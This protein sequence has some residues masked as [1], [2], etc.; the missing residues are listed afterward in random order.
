[1]AGLILQNRLSLN[2]VRPDIFFG[3][4]RDLIKLL[5]EGIIEPEELIM[6][7]GLPTYN[8][9]IDAVK[10]VNGAGDFNWVQILEETASK[11]EAGIKLEKYGRKLQHGEDIDWSSLVSISG[12]VQQNVSGNF[13]PLSEV[14]GG[15]V[16]LIPIGWPPFDEHVGGLPEVGLIIVAGEAGVGKTTLMV[17]MA[18]SSAGFHKDKTVLIFSLEMILKEIAG[19]IRET[20]KLN[21]DI[22]SRIL[23]N[24]FPVTPE[25][26]INKASTV[27]NPGLICVDFADYMINGEVTESSMAHIYKTLAL[28]AKSLH[29]PILLLS[30]LSYKYAGGIPRPHHI[31]YT[32]L[33][34]ALGWMILMP[35]NPSEDYYADQ[36]KDLLPAIDGYSYLIVWKVRG[37]FR[38]H[39]NE[40]PG[41]IQ[42]QFNGSHGWSPVKGRWFNLRKGL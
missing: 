27:E 34:K 35:Y 15:E 2:Q 18:T 42:I 16:P 17:R 37:G 40:S 9:C 13:T 23:L 14:E 19:R 26:V 21:K 8:T 22:E 20:T 30:Q 31:R 12:K 5:K 28:G 33:A 25:E 38:K 4:Y 11:H 3:T 10:N 24:D 32:S 41:A 7:V 6:R 36:D 1:V 29:C 39:L